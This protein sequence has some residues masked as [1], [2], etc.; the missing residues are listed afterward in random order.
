MW[1][2]YGQFFASK[3]TAVFI[4]S[5]FLISDGRIDISILDSSASS[6][7][8]SVALFERIDTYS[9]KKVDL[10]C[11]ENDD[12]IIPILKGNQKTT[13]MVLNTIGVKSEQCVLKKRL[14]DA[15]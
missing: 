14:T 13:Y 9:V 6:G 11:Y 3:E 10:V 2:K 4:A 12:K 1:K 7:I 15:Q 5:L 8:L